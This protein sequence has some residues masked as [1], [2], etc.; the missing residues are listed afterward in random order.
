D[1][2]RERQLRVVVCDDR[3]DELRHEAGQ[4]STV[5]RLRRHGRRDEC[6]DCCE[7]EALHPERT[8]TYKHFL[9]SR[10]PAWRPSLALRLT[11][12]K[13]EPRAV[14]RLPARACPDTF[15]LGQN[16]PMGCA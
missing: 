12:F 1:V 8:V 4:A 6:Q 10:M 11:P 2:V 14:R 7:R 13:A 3:V 5:A 15:D 9:F 16:P